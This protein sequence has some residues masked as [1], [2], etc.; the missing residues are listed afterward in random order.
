[1]NFTHKKPGNSNFIGKLTTFSFLQVFYFKKLIAQN[2]PY[3]ATAFPLV[4]SSSRNAYAYVLH[5]TN[6]H[7]IDGCREK[8]SQKISREMV[9]CIFQR[10][11]KRQ[12]NKET[13]VR[14]DGEAAA[15]HGAPRRR[16][17]SRGDFAAARARVVR[18]ADG[19]QL[20]PSSSLAQPLTSQTLAALSE[21]LL[22]SSAHDSSETI[23]LLPHPQPDS[24]LAPERR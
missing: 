9:F 3:V 2:N 15:A 11:K 16:P 19:E 7:K 18:G 5:Y 22:R 12:R 23:K 10:E 6:L 21:G 17:I 8:S 14:C 1:M 4:A 13:Y 24:Q 20:F